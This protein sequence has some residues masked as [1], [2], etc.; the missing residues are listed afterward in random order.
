LGGAVIGTLAITFINVCGVIRERRF[1][2]AAGAL[3]HNNGTRHTAQARLDGRRRPSA[4]SAVWSIRQRGPQLVLFLIPRDQS[5]LAEELRALDALSMDLN[6][7][8]FTQEELDQLFGEQ[9][10]EGQTDPDAI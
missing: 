3:R 1:W 8:G 5:L 9:T 4:T 7:L 10:Q 2:I 6:L